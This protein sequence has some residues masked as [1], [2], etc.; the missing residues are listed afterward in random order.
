ML[1]FVGVQLPPLYSPYFHGHVLYSNFSTNRFELRGFIDT[2]MRYFD[3]KSIYSTVC[4]IFITIT[5]FYISVLDRILNKVSFSQ[6]VLSVIRTCLALIIIWN[7]HTCQKYI[8]FKH[9]STYA[10]FQLARKP[11]ERINRVNRGLTAFSMCCA[12]PVLLWYS[13]YPEYVDYILF[14]SSR[15]KPKDQRPKTGY[16]H[17]HA[18]NVN[19]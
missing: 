19:S 7:E 2:R 1:L 12:Y 9:R 16:T 13:L 15:Q 10:V 11:S 4:I 8:V 14:F 17:T 18:V 5:C 3:L 6:N